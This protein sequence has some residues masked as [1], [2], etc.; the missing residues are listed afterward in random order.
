[1]VN[2]FFSR[3]WYWKILLFTVGAASTAVEIVGLRLIAPLFGTSLPVWGAVIAAVLAGLALGYYLGGRIAQR[4]T[5]L[6]TVQLHAALAAAVFLWLPFGIQVSRMLR[7]AFFASGSIAIGGGALLTAWLTLLPP[8][9]LF[10]MIS[11]LAVEA[12][13]HEGGESAGHSAGSVFMLTTLGS[14]FGILVPSLWLV[15]FVGARETIWIFS[16]AVLL[17]CSPLLVRLKGRIPLVLF[18]VLGLAMQFVLLRP[19]D[20]SIVLAADT[21]YQYV[22][23]RETAKG[24]LALI[25]DAGFG[26]QS[27]KPSGLYTQ[28]YWD[29][30]AALPVYLPQSA[31]AL[32]VLVLGSAASATERQ[33]ERF[34]PDKQFNFTSVDVDPEVLAIADEYFDPPERR[35]IAADARSYV[36]S[37][38]EL[39]DLIVVDAYSREFT[40]PFHLTTEEFFLALRERL[41]PGGLV[42]I[43]VIAPSPDA[44]FIRSVSRTMR[45]AWPELVVMDM[46]QSC[47]HLIVAS[48]APLT[49]DLQDENVPEAVRPLLPVLRAA[50]QPQVDGM[51]FTDNR[52]PTDILAFSSL[53]AW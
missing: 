16:G 32:D 13:S 6:A 11:P 8:S 24:D 53:C 1:M 30:L 5:T 2:R 25:F 52:A 19:D 21:A 48:A 44:F 4:P 35:R 45:Q 7:D 36:T 17:L 39:F 26:I 22:T 12:Q 43:N 38:D 27:L 51:L 49:G 28:G 15:P 50:Q 23:V 3:H 34:W 33:M 20:P 31:S 40:V 14:L 42:A 41:A 18:M 9:I 37:S 47:N 46:P 10:G 29:Y